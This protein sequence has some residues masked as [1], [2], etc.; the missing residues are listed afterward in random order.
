MNS[1]WTQV[2]EMMSHPLSWREGQIQFCLFTV[3]YFLFLKTSCVVKFKLSWSEY[4]FLTVASNRQDS[5]F[6]QDGNCSANYFGLKF[7]TMCLLREFYII[8]SSNNPIHKVPM[9]PTLRTSLRTTTPVR[10]QRNLSPRRSWTLTRL[11]ART[12]LIWSERPRRTTMR[13]PTTRGGGRRGA[14]TGL[15]RI[16]LNFHELGIFSE[17]LLPVT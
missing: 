12:G 13:D 14:S 3:Q 7:K 8:S 5:R 17:F 6:I 1:S 2:R 9:A 4:D 15:T 16:S 11:V 10:S